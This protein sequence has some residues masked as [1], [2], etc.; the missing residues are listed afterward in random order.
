MLKSIPMSDMLLRFQCLVLLLIEA[1]YSI[2]TINKNATMLFTVLNINA[3]LSEPPN[4]FSILTEWMPYR[5][6]VISSQ[7]GQDSNLFLFWD[8]IAASTSTVVTIPPLDYIKTEHSGASPAFY[9]TYTSKLMV[10]TSFITLFYFVVRTGF[11]PI[12][13]LNA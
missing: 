4:K 12:Q 1:K 2:A 11:E 10:S 5:K 8:Y 7:S 9:Y 3:R 6:I 13:I